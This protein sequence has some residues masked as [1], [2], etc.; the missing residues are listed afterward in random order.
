MSYYIKQGNT[1]KITPDGAVDIRTSLPVGTY[2]VKFDDMAGQFYLEEMKDFTF[3]GKKYGN[4]QKTTDRIINTFKSRTKSTG[5]LLAGEKGSGKTLQAKNIALE[6]AKEN[7]PT[8]IINTPYAGDGF[9]KFIQ[10][11]DQDCVI[12]FDEFEKVYV[13]EEQNSILTLLDGTFTGKKLFILTINE[14]HRINSYMKNR[15]GRLYYMIKY[16]ALKEEF[17]REYCEDNCE[18]K[19]KIDSIVNATNVFG[20]FNFD[21]LQAMVEEIN[22]YGETPQEVIEVLNIKP[23]FSANNVYDV[24]VEIEGHNTKL[25]TTWNGN[26]LNNPNINLDVWVEAEIKDDSEWKEFN[27]SL[28]NMSKY[29]AETGAYMFDTESQDKKVKF[30]FTKRVYAAADAHYASL[31]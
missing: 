26:F 1:F 16:G 30:V 12:I 8:V 21:M 27:I 17:I 7:I 4:L 29:N 18:D 13:H 15:P 6:L 14:E 24:I 5:V 25:E 9:N 20:N 10:D 22:R 11:I 2:V 19:A 31:F 28:E 23:E 3:K